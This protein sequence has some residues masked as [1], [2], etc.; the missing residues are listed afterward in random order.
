MKKKNL[1]FLCGILGSLVLTGCSLSAHDVPSS[2]PATSLPTQEGGGGVSKE[3]CI[4][5]GE[6]ETIA[7]QLGTDLGVIR[8]HTG[9]I[10]GVPVVNNDGAERGNKSGNYSSFYSG[11]SGQGSPIS[12][13]SI[14]GRGICEIDIDLKED[15]VLDFNLAAKYFCKDCLEDI[16]EIDGELREFMEAEDLVDVALIDLTDRKLYSLNRMQKAYFIEDYY[17]HIDRNEDGLEILVVDAP[18]R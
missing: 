12:L 7:S 16:A 13:S 8:L 5:C 4:I 1:K 11:N 10:F 2:D 6:G 17:I 9:E 18:L 3:Q 14:E 15:S